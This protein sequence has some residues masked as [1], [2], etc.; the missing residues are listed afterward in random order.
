MRFALPGYANVWQVL[1][2]STAVVS[3]I[4][5]QDVVGLANDAGKSA[6]Q[7]F[8][9][10]IAVLLVYL[11]ITWVSSQ[12]FERLE[13]H[14]ARGIAPCALTSSSPTGRSSPRASG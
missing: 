13:R 10:F 6:H 11:A 1:V 7:P 5:L 8:L 2:K 12:A 3:V 14:H 4:G 9:F